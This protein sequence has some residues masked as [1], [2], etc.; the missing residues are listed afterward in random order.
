MNSLAETRAN[1]AAFPW[2]P[3]Y[4]YVRDEDFFIAVL[5]ISLREIFK[6]FLVQRNVVLSITSSPVFCLS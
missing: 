1:L 3:N 4:L 6:N 5:P 2:D